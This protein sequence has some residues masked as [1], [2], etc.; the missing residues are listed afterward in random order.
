MTDLVHFILTKR[1]ITR[2]FYYA[3]FPNVRGKMVLL[4]V[5][6]EHPGPQDLRLVALPL[7]VVFP[8]LFHHSP[9]CPHVLEGNPGSVPSC[10]LLCL[11]GLAILNQFFLS[12]WEHSLICL[13]A[14][15]SQA[16]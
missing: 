5:S 12:S 6:R 4:W 2:G 16:N 10:P 9:Y 3:H 15:P 7:W 1:P 13:P 11:A 14:T 8:Q